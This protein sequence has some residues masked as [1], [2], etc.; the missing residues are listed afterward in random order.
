M[1]LLELWAGAGGTREQAVIA[2]LAADLE[3][4]PIDADVWKKARTLAQAC[5]AAGVRAPAADLLIA[6]CAHHHGV[7]MIERDAHFAQIASARFKS[8]K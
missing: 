3:V 6:A 2:R 4:L 7:D 8:K 5:R 1:V